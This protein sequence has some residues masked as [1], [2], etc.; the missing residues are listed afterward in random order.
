[1]GRPIRLV[2]LVPGRDMKSDSYL[3]LV[4]FA[5]L[6]REATGSQLARLNALRA[7]AWTEVA[8][9]REARTAMVRPTRG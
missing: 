8:L 3:N 9:I 5:R 1:M 2:P 4:D 6:C 7:E